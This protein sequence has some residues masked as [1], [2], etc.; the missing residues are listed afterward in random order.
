MK[1]NIVKTLNEWISENEDFS[2]Y[3]SPGPERFR[4]DHITKNKSS[5]EIVKVHATEYQVPEEDAE[6]FDLLDHAVREYEK[7]KRT[8]AKGNALKKSTEAV[9]IDTI[10]TVFDENDKFLT[11]I[12]ETKNILL[13]LSKDTEPKP[14][15]NYEKALSILRELV[16]TDFPDINRYIDTAIENAT[17]E[18]TGRRGNIGKID[19]NPRFT[20]RGMR[21]NAG[22]VEREEIENDEYVTENFI[23]GAIE[24]G[25]SFLMKI[26]SRLKRLLV[27][28]TR[29]IDTVNSL[30]NY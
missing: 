9:I 6:I 5:D 14:K 7:A 23:S 12:I 24:K 30:L 4:F 29:K 2:G 11:R 15:V 20:Y 17:E 26:S 13:T 3:R 10:D 8:I 1:K 19:V 22:S 28:V 27:L 16:E 18:Q 25:K 21:R